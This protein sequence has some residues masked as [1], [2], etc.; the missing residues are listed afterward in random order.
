MRHFLISACAFV[1]VFLVGNF[2]YAQ[3]DSPLKAEFST[4]PNFIAG[5]LRAMVMIALPIIA[6]FM[7]YSG[8]LFILA[9]GN[10]SKLSE[11]KQNFFYVI[12]GAILI[13]GAW[14]L[15]TMIGGTIAQLAK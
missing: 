7:V 6:L 15:A 2:A 10:E 1:L 11:A 8:F 5:A 14:V 3:F 4:I 12:I 9:R 13:L